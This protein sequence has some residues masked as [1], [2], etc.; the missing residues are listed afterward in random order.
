MICFYLGNEFVFCRW[1]GIKIVFG[2]REK[3]IFFNDVF[4]LV[5]KLKWCYFLSLFKF[6]INMVCWVFFWIVCFLI[7]MIMIVFIFIIVIIVICIFCYF[8]NIFNWVEI[9]RYVKVN[10]FDLDFWNCD[11]CK[12]FYV[13]L[14]YIFV[15]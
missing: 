14:L 15:Y 5:Y 9:V 10:C 2:L 13:F 7:N 12:L 6:F 3:D 1:G 11:R 4:W 8:L